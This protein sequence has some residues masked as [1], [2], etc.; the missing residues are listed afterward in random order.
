MGQRGVLCAWK[1]LVLFSPG[2]DERGLI[3]E[4]EFL[5]PPRASFYGNYFPAEMR[6]LLENAVLA[7]S[8]AAGE[9]GSGVFGSGLSGPLPRPSS[10]L[11]ARLYFPQKTSKSKRI[12]NSL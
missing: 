1:V 11:M 3:G 4:V 12:G 5:R 8:E 6:R 2:Y 10:C 7:C 9:R